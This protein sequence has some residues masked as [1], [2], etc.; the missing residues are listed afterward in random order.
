MT[1][2]PTFKLSPDPDRDIIL[3][4][5]THN[6]KEKVFEIDGMSFEMCPMGALPGEYD[7]YVVEF[8]DACVEYRKETRVD[9]QTLSEAQRS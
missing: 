5:V 7:L 6:D 1:L 2:K 8:L 3:L 4:T 9:A